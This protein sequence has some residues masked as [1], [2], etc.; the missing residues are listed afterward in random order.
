MQTIKEMVEG[1][2]DKV[3]LYNLGSAL[4][5]IAVAGLTYMIDSQVTAYEVAELEIMTTHRD[6]CYAWL[7]A[8]SGETP[9]GGP[10]PEEN[11]ARDE[12]MLWMA[13]NMDYLWD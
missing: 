1:T 5:R 2:P 4:L 10:T 13:C 6:A 9:N 12:A 7:L 3:D 8:D 11:A